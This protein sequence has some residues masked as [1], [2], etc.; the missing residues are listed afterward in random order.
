MVTARAYG[1]LISTKVFGKMTS[2]MVSDTNFIRTIP[3]IMETMLME[4]NREK[5]NSSFA[6]ALKYKENGMTIYFKVK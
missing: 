1:Q 6:T 5:V 4:E 3:A 2:F